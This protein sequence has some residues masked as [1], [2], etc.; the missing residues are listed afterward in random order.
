MDLSPDAPLSPLDV[1]PYTA[2]VYSYPHKTAYRVFDPI[3]MRQVWKDERK[4]ALFLYI[5]VP[6]CEMR[7]GFCNLF[8][9]VRPDGDLMDATIDA[10]R[11][12]AAQAR[13]AIPGATFARMAIGGGTP[14]F[15]S[16]A[17][18]EALFEIAEGVMGA[19]PAGVPTSVEVSPET[20]TPDKLEILRAH[21]V[22]RVSMGVQSFEP[23]EVDAISRLQRNEQVHRSLEAMRRAGFETLNV[24]L[25]YGLPHQTPASWRRSIEEALRYSPEEIYLYP[26]YVRPLTRMG[27]SKQDW[28]DERLNFYRQG[29]DLLLERGY[30]QVSMRMF[31][32]AHAPNAQGPVYRCQ[33]DGM[34]GLGC[35]A[36][37]YTDGLHYSSE[38][39]V[40]PSGVK[41]ILRDFVARTDAEFAEVRYGFALDEV[42]RRR[43]HAILSLLSEEGLSRADWR[44]RFGGDPVEALPQLA[45]L[46][47]LGLAEDDGA[48]LRLTDEG[49]ERSD[50]IGPWLFSERVERLMTDYE[51]R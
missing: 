50:A 20:A 4:E 5:H 48:A 9:T 1:S 36:R 41:A 38:Y 32:A 8:T 7:C 15:L 51:A 2:Y 23:D 13:E 18:L 45:A 43:R 35:G 17:Q 28:D 34:V 27:A 21:G 19:N 49:M 47:P 46:A 22:D 33:E 39:A 29:R 10:V 12:Q 6:F 24:D 40:G 26:L 42:E 30:R 3:P 44:R 25:M 16:C 37:S 14:T 31:R 11:R